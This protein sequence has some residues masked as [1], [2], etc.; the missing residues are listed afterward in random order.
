MKDTFLDYGSFR[1]GNGSQIRFWED[2]W[3]GS[4]PL[5]DKFPGLFNIVRRKHDTVAQ[6]LRSSPLNISFHR[7]LVANNLGDWHKIVYSILDV[8]LR[9]DWDT[10]E[11][12]YIHLGCFQL[13]LCMLR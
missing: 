1:L 7:T 4:I 3:L 11:G 9:E 10:S 12:L 2:K 13:S 5:K 6:V 8:S